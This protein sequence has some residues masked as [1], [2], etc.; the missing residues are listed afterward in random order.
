MNILDWILLAIIALLAWYV[1]AETGFVA[2]FRQKI[3]WAISLIP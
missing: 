1:L 3:E 2:F